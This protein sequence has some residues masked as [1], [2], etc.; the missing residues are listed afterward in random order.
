MCMMAVRV[1]R[2][3]GRRLDKVEKKFQVP[4]IFFISLIP[5][6]KILAHR[7]KIIDP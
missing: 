7:Q 2:V 6:S 4:K 5:L 1:E 3:G